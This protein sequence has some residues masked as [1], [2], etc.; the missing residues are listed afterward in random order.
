MDIVGVGVGV[1]A[2][3]QVNSRLSKMEMFKDGKK[4]A[5]VL[6]GTGILPA[7]FKVPPKMAS[8]VE[9]AIQGIVGEGIK[10]AITAFAPDS[11]D[12]L[13]PAV[14]GYDMSHLGYNP[15]A[16]TRM[17]SMGEA[18]E[19]QTIQDPDTGEMYVIQN[20]EAVPVSMNGTE[21]SLM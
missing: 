18:A 12:K 10:E 2:G 20:G 7:L 11:V 8:L 16:D 4:R 6:I 13:L 21:D 14:S 3:A 5:L 9:N 19:G 15:Y 1:V 17:I